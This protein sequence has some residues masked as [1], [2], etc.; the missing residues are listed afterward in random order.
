MVPPIRSFLDKRFNKSGLTS[1]LSTQRVTQE[2][3]TMIYGWKAGQEQRV[4]EA[5]AL[6]ARVGGS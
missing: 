3:G 1:R 2:G 5:V 6:G 4:G